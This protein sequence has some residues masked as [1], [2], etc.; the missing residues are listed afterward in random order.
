MYKSSSATDLDSC[1]LTGSCAAYPI[2]SMHGSSGRR[3]NS[4]MKAT[5]LTPFT[6]QPQSTVVS[7][8]D[9][10]S[11][12]SQVDLSSVQCIDCSA[13]DQDT[14]M[15]ECI[16]DK[17]V[18]VALMRFSQCNKKA[19]RHIDQNSGSAQIE[20]RS[21]RDGVS[22]NLTNTANIDSSE[23]VMS[24]A[25]AAHEDPSGHLSAPRR[26]LQGSPL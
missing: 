14:F 1:K 10:N 23:G 21:E 8:G 22:H 3:G 19:N 16:V 17:N 2:S 20:R 5:G 11:Y 6:V 15:K 18:G 26:P 25:R 13:V 9:D 4:D 7:Q 24:G 12:E